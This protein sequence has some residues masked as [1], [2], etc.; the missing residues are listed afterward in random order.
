LLLPGSSGPVRVWID[1]VDVGTVKGEQGAVLFLAPGSRTVGARAVAADYDASY[2]RTVAAA[3]RYQQ[4][5]Q[6]TPGTRVRVQAIPNAAPLSR[7]RMIPQGTTGK[8]PFS[9]CV[10]SPATGAFRAVPDNGIW[11]FDASWAGGD[12]PVFSAQ[13]ATPDRVPLDV[14]NTLGY[15]PETDRAGILH[16]EFCALSEG[17]DTTVTF[18]L[19]GSGTFD[20]PRAELTVQVA[21]DAW[22]PFV[23]RV[24]AVRAPRLITGFGVE[25]DLADNPGGQRTFFVRDV[26]LRRVKD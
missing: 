12:T 6:V 26:T 13:F 17:G 4:P 5:L 16:L 3:M 24:P 8:A 18:F 9:E 21:A 25:I 10:L 22:Q 2:D 7:L 19:G 20:A 1:G 23:I 11:K 15:D 14:G